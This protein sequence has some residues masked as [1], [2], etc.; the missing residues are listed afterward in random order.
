MVTPIG[1]EPITCP[2]GGDGSMV[3]IVPDETLLYIIS[4]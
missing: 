3:T 2:L 1:F 4:Y